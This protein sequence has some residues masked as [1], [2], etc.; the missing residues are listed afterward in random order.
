MIEGGQVTAAMESW[1]PL[2]FCSYNSMKVSSN[3][4]ECQHRLGG[5]KCEM[6]WGGGL[7]LSCIL[8]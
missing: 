5:H 3:D 8:D 7:W 1:L 4:L 2:F 6:G